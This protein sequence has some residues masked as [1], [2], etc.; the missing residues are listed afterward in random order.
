MSN[1]KKTIGTNP[2]GAFE[3]KLS[4]TTK[5]SP[6]Q[7]GVGG[8]EELSSELSNFS[9]NTENMRK[10]A[11]KLEKQTSHASAS[12]KQLTGNI[13]SVDQSHE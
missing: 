13:V 12:A 1:I 3:K 2:F 4:G 10:T 9:Q 11:H 7:V 8:V 6:R 5:P